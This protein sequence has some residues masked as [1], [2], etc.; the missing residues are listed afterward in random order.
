MY[1]NGR[2]NIRTFSLAVALIA[3]VNYVLNCSCKSVLNHMAL[4]NFVVVTNSRCID[5][6]GAYE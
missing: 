4:W 2:M 6:I 5:A 1:N 3:A